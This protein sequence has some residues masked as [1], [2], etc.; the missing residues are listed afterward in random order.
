MSVQL[1]N[2]CNM[3]K[4]RVEEN[5]L[6][7]KEDCSTVLHFKGFRH[8][9]NTIIIHIQNSLSLDYDLITVIRIKFINSLRNVADLIP[10][11]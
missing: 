6:Y 4:I 10:Y 11:T 1:L 8:I 7:C 2:L 3:N 9:W 5:V